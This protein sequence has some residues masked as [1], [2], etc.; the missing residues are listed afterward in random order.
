MPRSSKSCPGSTAGPNGTEPPTNPL[1]NLGLIG[2]V[3]WCTHGD[4][5]V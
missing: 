4:A 1:T 2:E 3:E 5:A